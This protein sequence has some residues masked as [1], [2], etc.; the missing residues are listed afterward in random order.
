MEFTQTKTETENETVP[1]SI[2]FSLVAKKVDRCISGYRFDGNSTCYKNIT[3]ATIQNVAKSLCRHEN[4]RIV[5][6]HHSS[7]NAF[8]ASFVRSDSW[9]GLR[10]DGGTFKWHN[11]QIATFQNWQSDDSKG[12]GNCVV[13]LARSGKWETRSCSEKN[14]VICEHAALK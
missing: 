12:G 7:E 10:K 14:P 5:I 3:L 13:M 9:I 1:E 2:L 11:G 6:L 8:I 4:G